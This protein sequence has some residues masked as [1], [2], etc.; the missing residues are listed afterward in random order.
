MFYKPSSYFAYYEMEWVFL[1]LAG[2]YNLEYKDR[3]M[4]LYTLD[5]EG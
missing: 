4:V 2:L 5:E 1:A 3:D